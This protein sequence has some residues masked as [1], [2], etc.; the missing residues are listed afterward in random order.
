MLEHFDT[1][2]RYAAETLAHWSICAVCAAM[3]VMSHYSREG[4]VLRHIATCVALWWILYEVTEFARI[5]DEVDVDLAN[6]LASYIAGAL[7]TW[8]FYSL[9]NRYWRNTR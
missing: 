3:T 2:H 9:K 5:H 4:V 1:F 8:G 6:G 7:L